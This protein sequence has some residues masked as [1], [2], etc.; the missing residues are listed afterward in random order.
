MRWLQTDTINVRQGRDKMQGRYR[1]SNPT[2][3]YLKQAK[4]SEFEIDRLLDRAESYKALATR[5]T[6]VMTDG[7]AAVWLGADELRRS[8]AG[9]CVRRRKRMTQSFFITGTLPSLND[10]IAAN[11]TSKYAGAKTK[12]RVEAEISAC[13]LSARLVPVEGPV[14]MHYRWAEPNRRRDWDNVTSARKFIQDAL[15]SRGIL[16]G[17]GQKHVVGFDDAFCVDRD[18]PGCMVTIEGVLPAQCE[19]EA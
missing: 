1:K 10:V 5:I 12:V 6:A 17:D 4:C 15:V 9:E 19:S 13:I 16:R 18:R 14:R 3:E 7:R 11:R 8:S 2:I